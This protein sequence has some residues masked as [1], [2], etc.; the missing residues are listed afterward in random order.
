MRQDQCLAVV[1]LL[2]RPCQRKR[3]PGRWVDRCIGDRHLEE[4]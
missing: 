1:L 3:E 4:E 2:R